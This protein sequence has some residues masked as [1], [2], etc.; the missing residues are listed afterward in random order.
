CRS[1]RP[2][3]FSSTT[4]APGSIAREPASRRFLLFLARPAPFLGL[5]FFFRARCLIIFFFFLR[6]A[7]SCL[8]FF[9]SPLS[10]SLVSA[11][12]FYFLWRSS[13]C[14]IFAIRL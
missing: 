13:S 7:F 5:V 6:R 2:R 3:R 8:L 10:F 12:F 9:L 4:F 1:N 14:A 11:R